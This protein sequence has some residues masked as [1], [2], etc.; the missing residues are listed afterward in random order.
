MVFDAGNY[1]YA[2]ND[3]KDKDDPIQPSTNRTRNGLVKR[4]GQGVL[5]VDNESKVSKE[6]FPN[7]GNVSMTNLDWRE[8]AGLCVVEKTDLAP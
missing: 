8:R 3:G 7:K 5:P 6:Q 4:R 1:T 2:S